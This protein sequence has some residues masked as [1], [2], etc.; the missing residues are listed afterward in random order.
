MCS[1]CLLT[2]VVE[3]LEVGRTAFHVPHSNIKHFA[4]SGVVEAKAEK[5]RSSNKRQ[6]TVSAA[7]GGGD[8][9]RGRKAPRI[10]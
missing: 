4:G 7:D 9:N 1:V 2:A 10:R 8:G 6:A 3:R 5:G